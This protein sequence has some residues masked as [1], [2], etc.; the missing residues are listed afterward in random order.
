[1]VIHRS[2]PYT[3][4]F[5]L[6]L[7]VAAND[8]FTSDLYWWSLSGA[9]HVGVSLA[10]SI[11]LH[12][13]AKRNA[14][15]NTDAEIVQCGANSNPYDNSQSDHAGSISWL[16]F[17]LGFHVLRSSLSLYNDMTRS[18]VG[19]ESGSIPKNWGVAQIRRDQPA[20]EAAANRFDSFG[21]AVKVVAQSRA[22][23]PQRRGSSTSP[24][25]LSACCGISPV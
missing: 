9:F 21:L 3:I 6:L 12:R 16:A 17:R 1:M 23:P 22:S 7:C 2:V 25:C 24:R 15:C 8:S 14:D 5:P 18:I 19:A 13:G 10:G 4:A 20:T 11:P